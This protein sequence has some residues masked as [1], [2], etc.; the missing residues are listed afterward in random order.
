MRDMRRFRAEIEL[1]VQ[2]F[3]E[4]RVYWDQQGRWVLIKDWLL[5]PGLNRE[6]SH[7]VI[8]IS[9]HYGYGAP[10]GDCF[11]DPELKALNPATGRYE[12][13]PHYFIRYPYV[14]MKVGSPEKWFKA[15]WRYLCLHQQAGADMAIN[16]L[17]YLHQL[18]KF[19]AEPFRDWGSTFASYHRTQ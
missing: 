1:P 15:R 5:P 19:L 14:E 10:L 11:I 6:T 4:A 18:Y 9:E 2:R 16:I 17:N 13:I 7:V 3:G 8:L 12:E